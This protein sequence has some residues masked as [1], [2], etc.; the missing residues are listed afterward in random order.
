MLSDYCSRIGVINIYCEKYKV[1]LNR[2]IF[3]EALVSVDMGMGINLQ[4]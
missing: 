3:K 4:D 1:I 2:L